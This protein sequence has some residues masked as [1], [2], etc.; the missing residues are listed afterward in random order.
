MVL[1]VV[2]LVLIFGYPTL[3]GIREMNI[4]EGAIFLICYCLKMLKR[5]HALGII[6]EFKVL[7]RISVK[8]LNRY[9]QP[10]NCPVHGAGLGH[11]CASFTPHLT[12]P[13]LLAATHQQGGHGS[14]RLPPTWQ[15]PR[16]TARGLT[17]H[18]RRSGAPPRR[19]W[20]AQGA[21]SA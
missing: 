13:P 5:C 7:F 14:P 2:T 11:T 1:H 8:I 20:E 3:H 4:L 10:L 12:S 21:L 6:L 9:H 19:W 15:L 18:S 16:T 17:A